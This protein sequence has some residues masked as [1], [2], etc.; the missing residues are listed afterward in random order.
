M[1]RSQS[2]LL[3]QIPNVN[4]GLTPNCLSNLNSLTTFTHTPST[5][6]NRKETINTQLVYLPTSAQ[7]RPLPVVPLA[8]SSKQ[9]PCGSKHGATSPVD[10]PSVDRYKCNPGL[11]ST[12]LVLPPSSLQ[13]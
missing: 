13:H 5:K 11:L 9:V 10:F 12:P 1:I 3:I 8:P 4:Q 2:Q 6:Q 7:G